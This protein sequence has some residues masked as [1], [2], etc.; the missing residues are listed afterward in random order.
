MGGVGMKEIAGFQ[1]WN[2]KARGSFLGAYN[3]SNYRYDIALFLTSDEIITVEAVVPET[4]YE[5]HKTALETA[6]QSL[7]PN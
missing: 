6:I 1:A 3:E 5:K 4:D 7:H 2:S